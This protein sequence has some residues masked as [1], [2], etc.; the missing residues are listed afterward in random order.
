MGTSGESRS[1]AVELALLFLR[2]LEPVVADDPDGLLTTETVLSFA[3]VRR[4]DPP[5][6]QHW[7]SILEKYGKLDLIEH[8]LGEP[9]S[10]DRLLKFKTHPVQQDQYHCLQKLL[11]PNIAST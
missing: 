2:E 3:A 8:M 7:H 4:E 5:I 11:P 10:M 1:I 9:L 6:W